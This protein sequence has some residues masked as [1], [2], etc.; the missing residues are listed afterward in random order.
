MKYYY[1]DGWKSWGE[2]NTEEYHEITKEKLLEMLEW[3]L[4]IVMKVTDDAIYLSSY[5]GDY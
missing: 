2:W 5:D 3:D 4:V 1:E